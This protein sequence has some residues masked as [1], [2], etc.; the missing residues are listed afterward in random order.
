MTNLTS[1]L[2]F[3][4]I[5]LLKI[6]AIYEGILQ[7]W[8]HLYRGSENHWSTLLQMGPGSKQQTQVEET[9]LFVI[10][11]FSMFFCSFC[12]IFNIIQ[13]L[14]QFNRQKKKTEL[15]DELTHALLSKLQGKQL[16]NM[17]DEQKKFNLNIICG[18]M[19]PTVM[20]RPCT[21]QKQKLLPEVE[22]SFIWKLQ[23]WEN[24]E[25]YKIHVFINKQQIQCSLAKML[26][27]QVLVIYNY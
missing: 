12:F 15:V 22:T 21:N 20:T 8:V 16:N 1:E 10:S 26:E 4:Y 27:T 25:Y 11:M 14:L 13:K 18:F 7:D 24:L 23:T 3:C 2:S 17:Q 9:N 5:I 6:K 19:L